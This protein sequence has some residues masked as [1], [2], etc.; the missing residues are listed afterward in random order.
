MPSSASACPTPSPQYVG[1]SW[2]SRHE[3]AFLENVW[4][5]NASKARYV[6]LARS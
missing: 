6:S 5:A 1:Y 2:P 4:R 3:V